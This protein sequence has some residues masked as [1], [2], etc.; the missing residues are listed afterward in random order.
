M[1][2]R[3]ATPR[4]R[5]CDWI[6]VVRSEL[7][8]PKRPMRLVLAMLYTHMDNDSG[9][10]WPSQLTLAQECRYSEIQI[11]RI[12]KAAVDEQWLHRQTFTRSGRRGRHHEY[13]PRLPSH[14]LGEG[15]ALPVTIVN[16]NQD[17]IPVIS[18]GLPVISP[19]DHRSQSRSPNSKNSKQNSAGAVDN[20]QLS[21]SEKRAFIADARNQLTRKK[22]NAA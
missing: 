1:A 16:G 19:P 21:K 6:A 12:L 15:S 17:R 11:R 20:S 2:R 14:L 9:R 10:A 18:G 3:R 4:L 8:P 5:P 22:R 13:Y 7:G